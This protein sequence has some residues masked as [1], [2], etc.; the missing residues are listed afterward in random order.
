MKSPAFVSASTASGRND[1]KTWKTW[2]L[3]GEC[4]SRAWTPWSRAFGE[5]F[6]FWPCAI[7]ARVLDEQRWQPGE[8]AAQGAHQGILEAS[9][10]S[11]AAGN[12][13]SGASR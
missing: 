11:I 9:A 8:V 5:R 3:D 4:S 7:A 13:C 6:G 2:A 10:S 1:Q 12:G